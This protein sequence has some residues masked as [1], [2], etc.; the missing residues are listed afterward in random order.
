MPRRCKRRTLPIELIPRLL[1]P[2]PRSQQGMLPSPPQYQK[3]FTTDDSCVVPHR[4]TRAAHWCLVSQIGRDATVSPGYERMMGGN[5]SGR[6]S[7]EGPNSRKSQKSSSSG[8][9]TPGVCV[10]GRNVTNYT[11]ED[12]SSASLC[13]HKNLAFPL[14]S[15]KRSYRDLNPDRWIQSPEC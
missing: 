12:C 13:R 5:R 10:T 14:A 2:Y 3:T 4:G 9:R 1:I 15:G 6:H 7:P 11:N 8:N